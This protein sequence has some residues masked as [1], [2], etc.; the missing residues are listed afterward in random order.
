MDDYLAEFPYGATALDEALTYC[1]L[2]TGPDGASVSLDERVEEI[3]R[4]YGSEHV[5]AQSIT[6]GWP[7]FRE[8][9]SNTE[10]RLAEAGVL[11][12]R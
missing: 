6:A 9:V 2:M 1:D 5:G 11:V 10:R 4:R 12:T 3:V 8:A 7:E